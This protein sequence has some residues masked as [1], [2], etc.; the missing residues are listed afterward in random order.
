[1][2]NRNSWTMIR[3][4]LL[5]AASAAV[6]S[7]CGGSVEFRAGP[8]GAAGNAAGG[9]PSA[10]AGG[11]GVSGA[12]AGGLAD[13]GHV[14]CAG[15][16]VCG[17]GYKTV[18]DASGCCTTCVPDGSGGSGGGDPCSGVACPAIACVGGTKY[19]SAPGQCCGTC[20]QDPTACAQGQADYRSLRSQL[21]AASGTRDC[22]VNDDCRF[23]GGNASCDVTCEAYVVSNRAG[24][25]IEQQLDQFAL[26]KCSLC[27]ATHPPCLTLPPPFCQAG[28]CRYGV[29]D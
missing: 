9:A 16:A 11:S 8:G 17:L 13:C 5:F 18:L 25:S 27:A 3:A 24:P 1:M 21:L 23:L 14:A 20:V 28:Q 2:P 29:Y 12:G 7:A 26:Q 15:N 10:G 22:A 6:I 19:E 4:A